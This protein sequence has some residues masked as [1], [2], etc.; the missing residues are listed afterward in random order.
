MFKRTVLALMSIS[1]FALAACN[2]IHGAGKDIESAGDTVQ[3][4]SD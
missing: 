3:D 2:T 1:L 4:A